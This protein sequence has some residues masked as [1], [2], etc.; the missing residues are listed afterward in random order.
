MRRLIVVLGILFLVLVVAISVACSKGD[1]N[2]APDITS[3][4]VTTA[5]EDEVYSYAVQASDVGD[6]LTFSLDQAPTGMKINAGTGL[7]EWTPD[8]SSG[9]TVEVTVRVSDTGGH[10][11]IQNF[12]ITVEAVVNKYAV[13]YGISDY[14][15]PAINDLNFC[16]EDANS[17]YL[18]LLSQ[19]YSCKVYGHLKASDYSLYS[20]TATEYNVSHAVRDMV[21]KA[22][23]ND[24]V[25]F[26]A[27]GHA[28][29]GNE[30]NEACLLMQ[31]Y[32][33]PEGG[34]DG[35]YWDTELAAD[36]RDCIASQTF[37]YIDSCFA[38]AMGEVF[39]SPRSGHVMLVSSC[40][41]QPDSES[42][43]YT[44]YSHG[45]W[46]YF[47]LNKGLQDAGHKTYDLA[48]IFD[49]AKGQYKVFYTD[50]VIGLGYDEIYWNSLDQPV[51]HDSDPGTPIYP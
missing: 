20:G 50:P 51:L 44:Q 29:Y 15:D 39:S 34:M 45:A 8:S 12:T 31:D 11:D 26:V 41:G 16:D 48:K 35:T 2:S 18:Y 19:G 36:F 25:C 5:K 42:F 13:I 17:W 43:D 46:T 24:Y 27:S 14:L 23:S 47:F 22:D 4:T 28:M 33:T 6:T 3:T 32:G 49:W 1:S 9:S 21:A 10:S 40:M 7:I 38:D 30:S 37:I